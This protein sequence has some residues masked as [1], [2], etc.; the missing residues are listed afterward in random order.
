M[1]CTSKPRAATSVATSTSSLP[2]FQRV[3]DSLTLRLR[4]VAVQGGR[5]MSTRRQEFGERLG[6]A[7]HLDEDNHAIDRFRLEDA[8]QY[9]IFLMRLRHNIS[10]TNR[11]GGRRLLLDRDLRGLAQVLLSDAPDRVGHRG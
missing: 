4:D 8:M 7:L 6:G 3:D 5:T 1:R 2:D 10:L 9:F 11:V